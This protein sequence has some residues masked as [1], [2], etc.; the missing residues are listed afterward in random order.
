MRR[1]EIRLLLNGTAEKL[2]SLRVT[3][4][5]DADYSEQIEGTIFLRRGAQNGLQIAVS[6]TQIPGSDGLSRVLQQ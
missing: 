3:V 1:G 2:V 4:L 5:Q 6:P